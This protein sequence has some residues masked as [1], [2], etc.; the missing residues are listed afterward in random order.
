MPWV[1]IRRL[2]TAIQK[3]KEYIDRNQFSETGLEIDTTTGQL[4]AHQSGNIIFRVDNN[5][6]LN[7]EVMK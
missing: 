5:G 4:V 1:S 3:I 6:H 2:N 7:S